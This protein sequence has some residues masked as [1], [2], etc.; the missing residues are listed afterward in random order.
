MSKL[1]WN[2]LKLSPILLGATLL[3]ASRTQAAETTV[4]EVA[5]TGKS[6]LIAE[7]RQLDAKP[8]QVA[9]TPVE[10]TTSQTSQNTQAPAALEQTP[11]VSQ[12]SNPADRKSVV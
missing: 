2:T 6:A 1:F 10:S 5:P 3:L 12:L 9:Q 4:V 7:L 8:L 11:S